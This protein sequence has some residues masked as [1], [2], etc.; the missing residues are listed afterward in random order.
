MDSSWTNQLY[1]ISWYLWTQVELEGNQES[2]IL[3]IK[4]AIIKT[5]VIL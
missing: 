1:G 2:T 5:V 4:Y 3:L